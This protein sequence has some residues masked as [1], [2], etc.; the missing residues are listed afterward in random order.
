M[1]IKSITLI[2][3]QKHTNLYLDFNDDLNIISGKSEAGKS[4]IRRALSWILFN[5]N[6]SEKSYRR[7][8]TNETSVKVVLD[9]DFEIERIRSNSINRYILRH[10]DFEDKI[11]DSFG[12][13]IPEEIQ[14][15]INVSEIEADNDKINL[16][17]SE[18]I[19][20]PFLL[21]KSATFRSKLFNKL[22][23]NEIL[24]KLFKQLNKEH[25]KFKRKISDTEE[26]LVKQEEQLS[27]YSTQY[28]KLKKKL[29]LV[30]TKYEDILENVKI[31]EHLKDL[32]DKIKINKENQEFIKF[33]KA[34]IKTVSEDK[35][36]ELKL[37][38]EELNKMQELFNKL[39]VINNNIK[40]MQIKKQLVKSVK[41][42]SKELVNNAERLQRLK[43]LNEQ[44]LLNIK[45]CQ[46]IALDKKVISDKLKE[47]E[48]QLAE[49]WKEQ[50]VC[51]LC[52][53][54]I[55]K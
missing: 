25:L 52:K 1:K 12:K 17:I 11:F 23:G 38:A 42:D 39:E 5:A 44:L 15:V 19:T 53:Q 36:N 24:D 37:Q 21:D 32:S 48:K 40:T 28:K 4:C 29:N 3:W 22:T 47:N 43:Q 9:N 8:G 30:K 13:T 14:Q 34:Q 31:Y 49:I 55:N 50:K 46:T 10:K 2:N 41:F 51:P 35:L 45:K 7:E 33:K 54:E 26:N 27:D 6:I 18:Q 20:L 16:N